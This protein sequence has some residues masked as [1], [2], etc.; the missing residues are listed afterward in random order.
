EGDLVFVAGHPGRTNR[1]N[2]L[3][4][5][6]YLRDTSMPLLL[7][8][9]RNREAHLAEYSKRGAE[10][11]RQAK[12]DLFSI[13]NSRKARIG[14]L[15]GLNDKEFMA[16]KAQAESALRRKLEADPAKRAAYAGAWDKLGGS[17]KVAR[18]IIVPE[19]FLERGFAFDSRL[20]SIARTLV[21]L[22]EED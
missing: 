12:E 11:A 4:H 10:Q 5:L 17:L 14:G 19:A 22:A 13:Q 16:R 15:G 1:L 9:L 6:E 18:E 7:K 2:T 20:F 21:R 3:A 8:V